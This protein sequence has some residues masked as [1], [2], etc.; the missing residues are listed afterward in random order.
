MINYRKWINREKKL[1]NNH[2]SARELVFWVISPTNLTIILKKLINF[3]Q[4]P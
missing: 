3:T 4:I 2:G 1:D